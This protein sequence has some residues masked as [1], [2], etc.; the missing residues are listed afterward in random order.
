M[1]ASDHAHRLTLALRLL[2]SSLR[3]L[4]YRLCL[5]IIAST[6]L[7]ASEREA[8]AKSV[9]R[10]WRWHHML[11]GGGG[12]L[13]STEEQMGLI[14]ELLVFERYILSSS[15]AP[16][17][18]ASWRGPLGEPK[19]FEI[20]R[21]AI[22]SKSRGTSAAAAVHI[23]SEFQ[24]DDAATDALFLHL[25]VLDPAE[26]RDDRGFTVT[27]T[28]CRV[29]DRLQLADNRTVER[30]NALLMAAGFRYEDDYSHARWRGGERS[31]SRVKGGFPRL[32][33]AMIP[34]GVAN[35]QYMLSLGPCG[36]FLVDPVALESALTGA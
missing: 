15:S 29:R 34:A 7:A 16:D 12:G 22:E 24:L 17:A 14:G 21:T 1:L 32:T 26:E 20:G 19:D 9:A 23:S 35:V 33:P 28:A 10:T 5:D 13:L 18:L 6:D 25:S 30:F 11:R 27:D 36:A 4:F 31:I 2:N 8:V 3:D